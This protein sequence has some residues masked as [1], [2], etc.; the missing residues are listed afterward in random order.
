M[1]Q[2][3]AAA[4]PSSAP[5]WRTCNAATGGVRGMINVV[6]LATLGLCS[7]SFLIVD[8][9]RSRSC[10]RIVLVSLSFFGYDLHLCRPCAAASCFNR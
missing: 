3:D 4:V 8:C 7:F 2:C 9:S 1:C 10:L 5:Q 6:G